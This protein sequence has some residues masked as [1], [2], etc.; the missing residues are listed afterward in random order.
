MSA[1]PSKAERDDDEE[2]VL[3]DD[4]LYTKPPSGDIDYLNPDI[5]PLEKLENVG[6]VVE[7]W[8]D[9]QS[10]KITGSVVDNVLGRVGTSIKD[11]GKDTFAGC[12]D[13][14]QEPI[15]RFFAAS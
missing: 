1:S 4:E 2:T 5:G 6:R 9:E 15:D 10:D 13:M 8:V 3:G 14:M 11:M 7:N 12:P